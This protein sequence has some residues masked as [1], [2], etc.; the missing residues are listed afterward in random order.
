MPALTLHLNFLE[1]PRFSQAKS[2]LRAFDNRY[3]NAVGEP[4]F[5]RSFGCVCSDEHIRL[6]PGTLVDD[7]GQDTHW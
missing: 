7:R 6:T 2:N 3:K 1:F 4:R 5:A